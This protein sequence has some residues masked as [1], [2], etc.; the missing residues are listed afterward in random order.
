VNDNGKISRGRSKDIKEHLYLQEMQEQDTLAEQ[1]GDD[2]K[3]KLQEVR[4]QV[5]EAC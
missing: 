1:Q 5:S 2:R 4:K 3:D